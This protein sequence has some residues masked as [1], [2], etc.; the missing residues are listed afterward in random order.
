MRDCFLLVFPSLAKCSKRRQTITVKTL[1]RHGDRDL[2]SLELA[3]GNP[4]SID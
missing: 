2:P 4:P 1:E 3:L